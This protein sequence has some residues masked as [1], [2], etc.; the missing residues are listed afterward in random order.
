MLDLIP[1]IKMKIAAIAGLSS[2]MLELSQSQM[3][4]LFFKANPP[5]LLLRFSPRLSKSTRAPLIIFK[6]SLGMT[7][8]NYVI[9]T[10]ISPETSFNSPYFS[11]P[12][13]S[14]T[15][16]YFCNKFNYLSLFF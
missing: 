7:T 11:H 14:S 16:N 6:S 1:P 5:I 8:T 13:N 15:N 12:C 3:L 4:C 2:Q 9:W 10:I